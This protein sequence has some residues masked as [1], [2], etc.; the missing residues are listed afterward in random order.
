MKFASEF[1]SDLKKYVKTDS[2]IVECWGGELEYKWRDI[3][4]G[5]SGGCYLS[6]IIE[7]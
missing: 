3:F 6:E 4:E 1:Y 7:F 2:T 5:T